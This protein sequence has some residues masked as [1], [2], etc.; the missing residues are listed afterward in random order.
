MTCAR[1]ARRV[2]EA[3][4]SVAGADA[5][6]VDLDRNKLTFRW[7]KE[8]IA[9]PQDHVAALKAAGY[10]AEL[11]PLVAPKAAEIL[12]PPCI[13]GSPEHSGMAHFK[14]THGPTR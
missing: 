10:P 3:S 11:I 9:N 8:T 1:C 14:P 2:Q 6:D 4:R 12:S 7:R 13:P 5:A